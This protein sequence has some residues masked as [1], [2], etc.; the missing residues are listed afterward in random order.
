MASEKV[1]GLIPS[2]FSL[3]VDVYLDNILNPELAL[4]AM[5]SVCECV[6]VYC[7]LMGLHPAPTISA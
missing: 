1:K 6:C 7:L 5:P 4:V 2:S 3:H